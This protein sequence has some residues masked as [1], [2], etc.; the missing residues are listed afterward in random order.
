MKLKEQRNQNYNDYVHIQTVI[1][2]YDGDTFINA[3]DTNELKCG[4]I[5]YSIL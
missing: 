4:T 1:I 2:N 5:M 3:C